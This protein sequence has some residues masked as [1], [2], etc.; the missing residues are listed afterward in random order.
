MAFSFLA[1]QASAH[2][3]FG[4][5]AIQKTEEK[6]ETKA[7]HSCCKELAGQNKKEDS[8]NCDDDG[9]LQSI[10]L[11]PEVEVFS[12][13]QQ[14]LNKILFVL[15]PNFLD[16]NTYAVANEYERPYQILKLRPRHK[17]GLYIILKRLRLC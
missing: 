11:S 14:S 12:L 16:Y 6:L 9:C 15:I 8:H 2:Q 3:C 13:T 10:S 7:D 4:D 5:C 1:T 17:L